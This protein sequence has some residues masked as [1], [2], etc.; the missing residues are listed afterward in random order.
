MEVLSAHSDHNFYFISTGGPGLRLELRRHQHNIV[1]YPQK[2]KNNGVPPFKSDEF[3]GRS[4]FWY[5]FD[6]LRSGKQ[7]N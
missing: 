3:I 4:Q 1:S 7:I 5:V 6:E 2:T